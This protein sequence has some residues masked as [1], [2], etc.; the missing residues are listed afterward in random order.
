MR[1]VAVDPSSPQTLYSGGDNGLYKSTNPGASWNKL[2]FP[3]ANVAVVA[4]NPKQPNVV[5]VVALKDR[6]GLVY[7]SE[8]GGASWVTH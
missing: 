3:G 5:L 6:E 4:V 8:D 1:T 7:R 2:G